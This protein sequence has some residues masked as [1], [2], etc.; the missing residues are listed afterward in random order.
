MLDLSALTTEARNME[1][2]GLDNMSA[3][4]I[5]RA[6]NREDKKVADAV[7]TVLVQVARAAEMASDALLNGGRIIYV[8]A[9]TSGRLGLLDAVECAPTFGIS[10]NQVMAVIAGGESAFLQAV[11][12]AEDDMEAGRRDMHSV[13]LTP[14]GL[15]LGIAA[16]GRTP[17]VCAALRYANSMGCHTVALAC[18]KNTSIGEIA[19]LPIEVEVGPEVLAGST[20]LKAGTAQKMILNMISTASMVMC[21]KVYENLMVDVIQTNV[22]LHLR[23]RN[24]VVQATGVSE[25]KADEALSRAGGN[26]KVAVTMILADTTAERAKELL[27]ANRGLVRL[28][29]A[30]AEGQKNET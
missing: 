26:T 20:R 12:G 10:N 8:G 23:A 24:I 21:G 7:E 18:N 5:V 27:Q 6:M 2:I 19:E 3:E 1:T 16:S 11:E 25:G 17:Y 4:E 15:V 22:K 9:G 30:Q 13:R 14:S 28:A 29:V